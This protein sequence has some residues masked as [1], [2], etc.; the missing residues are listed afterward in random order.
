M[1]KVRLRRRN[2]DTDMANVPANPLPAPNLGDANLVEP[3]DYAAQAT[4]QTYRSSTAHGEPPGH[5]DRRGVRKLDQTG[6]TA[7]RRS[8]WSRHRESTNN[9][10]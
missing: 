10:E 3:T 2:N 7:R 8:K 4:W 1:K 9:D 6:R 5:L